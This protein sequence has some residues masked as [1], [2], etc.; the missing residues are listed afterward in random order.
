MQKCSLACG[1]EIIQRPNAKFVLRSDQKQKTNFLLLI[2][3]L[4]VTI[5][6][7][8]CNLISISFLLFLD[9]MSALVE[10][11]VRVLCSE[12]SRIVAIILINL[13]E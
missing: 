7:L 5:R 13:K 1:V 4:L 12:A 2:G 6:A 3:F 11:I 8:I 10:N 9:M